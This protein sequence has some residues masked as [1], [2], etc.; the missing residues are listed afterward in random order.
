[1]FT[2]SAEGWDEY[3]K[4][5]ESIHKSGYLRIPSGRWNYPFLV[6]G[7]HQ[8][9]GDE[10]AYFT[11]TTDA[12]SLTMHYMSVLNDKNKDISD[13]MLNYAGQFEIWCGDVKLGTIGT[14][15][16]YVQPFI[17]STVDLKNPDNENIDITVKVTKAENA[18]AAYARFTS[19]WFGYNQ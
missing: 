14:G 8:G 5:D 16:T 10:G 18:Y 13:D 6:S 15:S 11:F 9:N 4:Y 1:M 12:N 7:V 17:S 2:Y 3:Y 19:I